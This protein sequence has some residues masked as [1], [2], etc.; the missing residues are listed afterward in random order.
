MAS[1]E[2]TSSL[3][4][5]DKTALKA[6]FNGIGGSVN[7]DLQSYLSLRCNQKLAADYTPVG[8]GLTIPCVF[9]MTNCG[10]VIPP[11][12]AAT[13]DIAQRLFDAELALDSGPEK[14]TQ[15]IAEIQKILDATQIYDPQ[16]A[17]WSATYY[18]SLAFKGSLRRHN[19]HTARQLLQR[20]LELEPKSEI[21]LYLT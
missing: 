4:S 18:G 1:M 19:A 14:E 2:K 20:A 8:G 9:V 6:I 10:P 7:P 15:A 12:S 3:A 21:L 17:G 11:P 13:N 5:L 16:T